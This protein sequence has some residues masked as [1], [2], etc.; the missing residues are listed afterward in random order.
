MIKAASIDGGAPLHYLDSKGGI[1]GIAVRVLDEIAKM[2]GL[3]FEYELYDSIADALE[4]D[5]DIF[6]GLTPH[7][8]PPDMILSQPYLK[9]QTILFA[10]SS[11]NPNELVDKRYAALEGGDLPEGVMEENAIYFANRRDTLNAVETGKADYGYGN[12][13]SVAFYTLQNGYKNILTVPLGKESR[14]YSIGFSKEDAILLS[15]INKSI[16]AIDE[17]QMQTFILDVASRVERKIDFSMIVD[18]YGK[19]ILSV[20]VVLIGI[21]LFSAITNIR[22]YNQVK[23]Q[24]KRYE[25]ISNISNECLFEYCIGSNHLKLSEKCGEIFGGRE[26]TNEATEKLKAALLE[27]SSSKGISTI[28]LPIADNELGVFRVISSNIYGENK[29][30][31]SIIGKL[32]DIT[33]EM[34]E[35]KELIAKAQID[36]LTSLYNPTTTK[37]LI[38]K[39]I[40]NKAKGIMDAF[41]LIDCD[42]FKSIND[43]FGHLTGDE[44][45]KCISDSLRLT[46]RETDIIGRIGGDEF[47]IYMKDIPSKNFV[48]SKCEDLIE[49]IQ[50]RN[51]DL[52]ISVSIGIAFVKTKD[53][54]ENIFKQAETALYLVKD[55]GGGQVAVYDK[56]KQI[57][58]N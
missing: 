3:V 32:I 21:L 15:I 44:G 45:L 8:T 33:E 4:S 13:F 9:S 34:A 29:K 11:L 41:I 6:F 39:S 19:E 1:K 25:L 24:N 38:I 36:G 31:Y 43:T 5:A 40:K 54:Y 53:K 23:L 10:N 28:R 46:F 12:E 37:K 27:G 22:A 50:K 48:R 18:A 57:L 16:E 51:Q 58:M 49:F 56:D 7:Y 47:C 52:N 2:T 14:E 42:K 55:M 26:K 35:K 17:S 30:L 20:T